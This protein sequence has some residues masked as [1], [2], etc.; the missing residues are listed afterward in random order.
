M[1]IVEDAAGEVP[2]E[3]SS[4]PEVVLILAHV[5]TNSIATIESESGGGRTARTPRG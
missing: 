4:M 1:L 3:V 2:P 5:D